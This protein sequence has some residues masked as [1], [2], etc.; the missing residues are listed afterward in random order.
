MKKIR[1]LTD[2]LPLMLLW[3]MLSAFL[4]SKVFMSLTDTAPEN[5]ITLFID[6]R[7]PQDTA[8]A[9]EM[10]KLEREGIEMVKVHPFTYAMMSG[11]AL[12]T[13]DLYIV[14]QSHIEE[15]KDWFAPLPQEMLSLGEVMNAGDTPSGL[16]IY[17]GQEGAAAQYI[18]YGDLPGEKYYLFFG[19]GSVHLA[20]GTAVAYAQQLLTIP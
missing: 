8:L 18:T 4:W 1:R 6:A 5:K 12:S 11:S 19:M 16:L 7:I 20:D 9:V 14:P 2:I 17:D 10:E 3:L 15:Y 13:A